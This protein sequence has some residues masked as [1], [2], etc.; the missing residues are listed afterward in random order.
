[1]RNYQVFGCVLRSDVDFPELRTTE[2]GAPNWTL[3][4]TPDAPE[5]ESAVLRG[6]SEDIGGFF[7]RMYR[8][9]HG[10]RFV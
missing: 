1:M 3:R 8:H 5:M 9:A 7:V 10:F 6:E 2:S 4:T